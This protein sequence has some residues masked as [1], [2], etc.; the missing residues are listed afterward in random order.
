MRAEQVAD[1]PG[2]AVV[3]KNSHSAGNPG[4]SAGV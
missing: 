1:P 4:A 3:P 2:T